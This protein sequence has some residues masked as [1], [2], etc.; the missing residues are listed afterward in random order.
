MSEHTENIPLKL[1]WQ[2]AYELR[3]C[4]D[5]A[6][7]Y[8]PEA[9]DNLQRHLA[10]CH[11]C[12]EKLSMGQEELTAWQTLRK[13]FAAAATK[14]WA[15]TEKQ[16]GQ[17]WTIKREFGGWREDGRFSRPPTV[18][19]LRKIEGSSGWRVAQ[20]F[21]DMRL[22]G[23]GDIFLSELY[24]FAE[25]WN[26]YSLKSDR[27]D[28]FLG[29][30]TDE[31]LQLLLGRSE[32][33]P[34]PAPEGSILSFFRRMEIEIGSFVALQAEG[35]L[36][37]E[38]DRA[39][40]ESQELIPGLSLLVTGAREYVL[41]IAACTLEILRGTFRPALVT[42]CNALMTNGISNSSILHTHARLTTEQQR[43]I[44]EHLP[45]VPIEIKISGKGVL[46]KLKWFSEQPVERYTFR[47][48]AGDTY[49]D[50]VQVQSGSS[51]VVT[52][53]AGYERFALPMVGQLLV[54]RLSVSE[55]SMT[56]H[57]VTR[58]D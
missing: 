13:R 43:I 46:I 24:G 29:E 37:E 51:D 11:L 45:A 17:V 26:C 53:T 54:F 47:V 28:K 48:M 27:F 40:D 35:E 56:I 38:W 2:T 42:R 52:I 25:S 21:S 30:V 14:P 4:P 55:H 8:F 23:D 41:D 7:L 57:L 36:V 15:G 9:D 32:S 58:I 20:L 50:G 39:P 33:T 44:M 19:L 10:I 22:M 34:E 3:T 18:L 12:R 16:A 6:T 1:A 49:L 31:Q 5:S